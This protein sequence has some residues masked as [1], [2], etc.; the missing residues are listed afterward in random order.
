VQVSNKN[1]AWKRFIF[2]TAALCLLL[3]FL[4]SCG[5]PGSENEPSG[6]HSLVVQQPPKARLTYV[7][8]GAS[9]TFGLGADDPE[10]QNWASD[11]ATMLG[12]GVHLINLGIPG[13]VLHQALDAELPVAID[14]H[15][16]LI[17]IWLAVNDLGNNVPLDSYAHDLDLMLTRLQAGAPHARILIANVPDLRL[18]PYFDYI[19]PQILYAKVQSYN[20]IIDAAAQRHHVTLVDLF[21]RWKELRQ[22]PE[23]IS[24][25]GF[26]P[27]TLGYAKLAGLFYQIIKGT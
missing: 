8:I 15:P 26:H 25:D 10:T 3:L 6:T 5:T 20:A 11:L 24:G 27:S 2:S 14:A 23:Y 7:A 1:S 9:D 4:A 13:L 21:S 18:V 19:N 22:H 16:N 17:T 12:P